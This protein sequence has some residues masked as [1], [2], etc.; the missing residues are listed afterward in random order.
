MRRKPEFVDIQ[1]VNSSAADPRRQHQ[2]NAM[3]A[4]TSTP[5]GFHSVTPY[6]SVKN[7]DAAIRFYKDVFGAKEAGRLTMPDGV[8]VHAELRLGDARIMLA[9][10][11]PQWGSKSPATLGGSPIT[12][13]LYVPDVDATFQRALAAGAKAIE[14]VKD[15]FY[16]DRAGSLTD[17]FGHKWMVQ[18]HIEDVPFDEA[19]RRC[20]AMFAASH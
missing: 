3:S 6:L 17:P 1:I 20:E 11:M 8:I 5:N 15:M 16:G 10:E 9:E 13:V 19:Q 4:T 18:T 12:L 7:A 14:P 2:E